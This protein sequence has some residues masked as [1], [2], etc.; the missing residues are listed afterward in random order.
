MAYQVICYVADTI[1]EEVTMQI[2]AH[3]ISLK[4]T[5]DIFSKLGASFCSKTALS[6]GLKSCSTSAR[7]PK[8]K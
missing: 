2:R 4:L 1:M 7:N 6:S 5:V 8:S 3:L